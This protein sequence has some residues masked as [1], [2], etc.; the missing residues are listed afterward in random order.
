MYRTDA[1]IVPPFFQ[2]KF[3]LKW[4]VGLYTGTK[5]DKKFSKSYVFGL[6][7]SFAY[8]HTPTVKLKNLSFPNKFCPTLIFF[9][10]QIIFLI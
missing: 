3:V 4:G 2:V 5:S 10:G 1:S 7:F 9:Q 8:I 6:P